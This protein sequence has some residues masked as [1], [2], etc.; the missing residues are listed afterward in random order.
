MTKILLSA[1]IAFLL[2]GT[3]Y[4]AH[5]TCQVTKET[6]SKKSSATVAANF[7]EAT[8]ASLSDGKS[9]GF[10]LITQQVN[11]DS[12]VEYV[13]I[14]GYAYNQCK[15]EYLFSSQSGANNGVSTVCMD[16]K[17]IVS[18]SCIYNN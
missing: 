8:T 16:N 3:T 10:S 2:A 7:N 4:A 9:H 11:P 14:D 15:S 5:A 17:A 13:E 12:S 18:V 6:H 1:S